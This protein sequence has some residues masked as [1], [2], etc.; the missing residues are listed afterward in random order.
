M[1]TITQIQAFLVGKQFNIPPYQRDYAWTTDQVEDIFEDISE[2]ITASSSHYLGTIV[3]SQANNTVPFDIVDGQQRL[4]TLMLVIHA[5]L[6]QIPASDPQRIGDEFIL[7][8]NGADLKLNFGKNAAF[9]SSLLSGTKP[10]PMTAGQR[11]LE[12]AYNYACGRA[13]ALFANGGQALIQQWMTTIKQLEIIQFVTLDTGRAIR[14]FQTVNDRGLPLSTMDKAKALLVFY[15]NVYLGGKHDSDINTHFGKC[16]EAFDKLKEYVR[17]PG[18]EIDNI[19]R[20]NFTE[21]DLLRYHYL[22]YD[23]P[24]IEGGFDY[25]GTLQTV[26]E[27]FL[28]NTLI[29]FSTDPDPKKLRLSSFIEDYIQDFSSFCE[30]FYDVVS[31]STTDTRLYKYF[32]ILKVSAALY[33]LTIR[34]HQRKLLFTPITGLTID[35]LKCLETCD[36]RVYKTRGTD[37]AKDIGNLSHCS[38]KE[39]LVDIAKSLRSFTDKFMNDSQFTYLLGLDMYDNRA[40]PIMLLCYDE[41]ISGAVYTTTILQHFV[42]EQITKEHIISQHPSFSPAAHGF[43]DDDEFQKH[44]HTLGNMMLLADHENKSCSNKSIHAK[45][46]DPNLYQKSIYADPKQ[47]SHHYVIGSPPHFNKADVKNRTDTLA[48][49]IKSEWRLW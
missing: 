20:K 43:T 14:L 35:I 24:D 21:D 7:L 16:F 10:T 30:A 26:F 29:K 9:V 34:L 3:L 49:W 19:S 39:S 40:L 41:H 45:M 18:F 5:L 36:I 44:L 17:L 4:S 6:E 2:A 22:A 11:K 1:S 25:Y 42:K 32:V 37:P 27:S 12:A 8:K 47:L 28:K 48:K 13:N 46:T 15:S 38:Q 23:Y 31:S 33:P